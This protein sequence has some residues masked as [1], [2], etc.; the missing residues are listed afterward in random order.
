VPMVIAICANG[1]GV[2]HWRHYVHHHWRH[3]IAIGAIFMAPLAPM[4]PIARTPNRYDTFTGLGSSLF[5]S[6]APTRPRCVQSIWH[7]TNST[8]NTILSSPIVRTAAW[9][10]T[11]LEKQRPKIIVWLLEMSS[12]KQ[13]EIYSISCG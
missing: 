1:D 4:A 6:N 12:R 2:L 10:I 13:T 11:L 7:K 8:M 5:K 3:W 9:L